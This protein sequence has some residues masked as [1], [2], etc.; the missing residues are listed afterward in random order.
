MPGEKHIEFGGLNFETS[1]IDLVLQAANEVNMSAVAYDSLIAGPVPAFMH[2]RSREVGTVE[3]AGHQGG[4][5][6]HD[7]SGPGRSDLTLIIQDRDAAA[8]ILPTKPSAMPS[9]F[10]DAPEIQ[11]A[12]SVM[13]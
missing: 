11:L 12:V 4:C 13:P 6:N 5:L 7:M 10:E 2:G 1:A 8:H 9:T 3:I